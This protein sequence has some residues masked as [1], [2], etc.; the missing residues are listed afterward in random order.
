LA[1]DKAGADALKS[2]ITGDT[3]TLEIKNGPRWEIPNRLHL[4]LTTNHVHAVAAG[5]NERRYFVL[6]VSDEKAGQAEWFDLLHAD[7]DNGG[8]E[9]FLWLLQNLRLGNWHP[10]RLPKTTETVDQ[11]QMSADSVA[12][13]A[14]ACCEADGILSPLGGP[15]REL[16]SIVETQELLASYTNY[17]R[18][19]N[20]RPVDD[21]RFGKALTA[22]FGSQARKR[23]SLVTGSKGR[24]YTYD[25]PDGDVWRA[26]IDKYLGI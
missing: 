5:T 15:T 7:L 18:Q 4:L 1:A 12:Q 22:M 13:W 11:Q 25:V 24:P 17:C 10:R 14:S 23:R 2:M 20:I 8:R 9:Q 16:G 26:A 21:K 3:L 19:R 6:D